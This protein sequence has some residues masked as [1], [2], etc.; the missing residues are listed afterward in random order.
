M[1]NPDYYS[2]IKPDLIEQREYQINIINNILNKNSLVVLPTGLGK[3]IIALF[4]ISNCLFNDEKALILAPTKPLAEQHYNSAIKFLNIDPRQIILITG[5]LNSSKRSEIEN[6]ARLIIATPQTIANDLKNGILSFKDFG[7]AVFDECHKAVGRYA[8]TYIADE[9]KSKNIQIIGLTASPGSDKKKIKNLIEILGIENI[10]VRI[11]TDPDV[12]NYIM[13]KKIEIIRIEKNKVIDEITSLL[14]PVIEEHLSKLRRYGFCYYKKFENIP[15]TKLLEI[16]RLISNVKAQNY[17]FI[18][19]FEYIYVLNLIHAYDLVSTEG[20]FPFFDY[21]ERLKNRKEKGR[22]VLSI[23]NNKNV[24]IAVNLA[25]KALEKGIEHKKMSKIVEI[26]KN[27]FS[28]KTV[29]IFAQYRSTVNKLEEILNKNNIHSKAFIGKKEGIT[30]IIQKNTIEDFRKGV[31]KVLIATS[32]GEEGLD[33]PDVDAV[34][35][36]EP[37]PNEIRNIQRRGRA[38]RIKFGEII[39]LVAIN[40]KDEVYLNVSKFRELKMQKILQD[41]KKELKS[42][43][44]NKNGQQKLNL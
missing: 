38:G 13:D 44:K 16:G 1:I 7:L 36:Y 17:K 18:L 24:M 25:K 43:I 40:T 3:T 29:I 6:N 28:G 23:L 26:L 35:F 37:I 11:P 32:I 8:Y 5:E 4:L 41:M 10:E 9:A 34:I 12:Y 30:N 22:A 39:I 14:K 2:L 27:K 21:F 20:L 19:L 33:I 15:K 42:N 31:F